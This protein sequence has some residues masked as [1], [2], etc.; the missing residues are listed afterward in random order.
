MV[1]SGITLVIFDSRIIQK[2]FRRIRNKFR[3]SNNEPELEL[4]SESH[5]AEESTKSTLPEAQPETHSVDRET[6]AASASGVNTQQTVHVNVQTDS[7]T[8]DATRPAS[9]EDVK[10]PYS[11]FVGLIILVFF[12]VSFIVIM[13]IRGVLDDLPQLFRFFAN[14]FLAGIFHVHFDLC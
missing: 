13:V 9:T 1:L 5:A 14:I 10:V 6:P 3:R 11:I 8:D 12:I 4:G 2:Y 7:Q